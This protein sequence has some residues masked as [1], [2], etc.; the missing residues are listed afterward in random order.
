MIYK[1]FF[2][3]RPLPLFGCFLR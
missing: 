3:Y 1:V 2:R